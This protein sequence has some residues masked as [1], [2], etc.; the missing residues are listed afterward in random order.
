MPSGLFALLDDVATIAKVAAASIDDIGAAASKAG[1]KAAGVVVDDAAVTPRYVTGFQPNRELPIIWRIAKG[2]LFNKLVLILPVL[3]LLSAVAQWAITPL[4]MVGGAYLCFEGAEKVWHSF[5]AKKHSLAEQAAEVVDPNHEEVMVK[6]AIRT[7]FILSAEIMVIALNE[8]L[9]EPFAMRAATLIVVAIA[10]TIAVY[11]AV[12]LIVKMD[13]IG[14][15]MAKE[16]NSARKAIGRGLVAFMP[17]LLGALALIGTAAML[18]VGGQI[19]LHGL[20]EYH[21]GNLGHG[22][23]DFAHALAGNL[24][25]AGLWEWLINAGGAGLFGLVLG[26]LIVAALHL[27]P[28]KKAAAH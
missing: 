12:G 9:T 14:L 18:W 11:G 26:G 3:L 15:H 28:G 7:D 20:D 6:G 19:V 23:H 5:A 16:G 22:L 24:P 27:V 1:V 13:D 21:I 10:I 2:S 17:K 4:L 25:G 8:V